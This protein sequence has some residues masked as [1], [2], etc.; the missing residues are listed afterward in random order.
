MENSPEI[1]NQQQVILVVDDE[2]GIRSQI[3]WALADEYRVLDAQ[4]VEQS[5]AIIKK[6]KPDL[7]TLDITLSPYGDLDGISILEQIIQLDP[8][9]KVIMIT[10]HDEKEI[11][12]KAI[13]LGAHDYYQKPINI[14]ELKTIVK[15]ALYIQRLELENELL[16]KKLQD[17]KQF[18]D[19][20]GDSPRMI[21][22]F[23]A[24]KRVLTIDVPVLIYG[25]SGTGKELVARAIHYQSRRCDH[26]FIPINC[27][28]IPENLLESELF[29]H[30]KGAFTG[31]YYQKKGKFE[32]ADKGT[33]F[34]DEIGELST[35]LQVK[36]LRFLQE[37]EIER[38]GGKVPISVDVRILAATNR[39]LEKEIENQNFRADL[40][41]RLSVISIDLPPLRERGDDILLL[42]NCFLNKYAA[43]YH[44][45]VFNF[46]ALAIKKMQHYNWPGNVRELENR[47]K[48]AVIMSRKSLISVDDLGLAD[49]IPADRESLVE[50]MDDIQ[51]KYILNA[52]S[53]TR[54][55]ISRAARELGISRV[56]LYELL[57]RFNIEVDEFRK[58][59]YLTSVA[60]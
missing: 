45:K 48:R 22:V 27:G 41:Y 23:D 33:A 5:I 39:N 3:K 4:N 36:L 12:I 13:Q 24:I 51:K 56:T 43:E 53:R 34:L 20:I 35:A 7:V 38:V 54:G 2:E 17:E 52:L 60:L 57:S 8:K 6:E 14:D 18:E 21:E 16:A 46:D 32:L 37:K 31:A 59:S 11:A 9:I 26:P 49:D 28:A 1:D 30:E 10:G 55:N 58:S 40:Y 25:E 47:I 44:K 19:M 15:R 42:A 50:V 29:G